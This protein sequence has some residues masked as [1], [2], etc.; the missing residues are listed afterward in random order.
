MDCVQNIGSAKV[1]EKAQHGDFQSTHVIDSL[2]NLFP[3]RSA[4]DEFVEIFRSVRA[5]I[6]RHIADDLRQILGIGHDVDLAEHLQVRKLLGHSRLLERGDKGVVGVEVG[7]HLKAAI[8]RDNL[9]LDVFLQDAVRPRRL[10]SRTVTKAFS[11]E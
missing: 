2:F 1:H 6:S 3:V 11:G 8:K 9:A 4:L 7:D 10:V 5:S